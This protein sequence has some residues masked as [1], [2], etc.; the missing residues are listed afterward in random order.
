MRSPAAPARHLSDYLR[1]LYR[2]RW[3]AGA[4]W[5]AVFVTVAVITFRTTPLYEATA[6]IEITA[7]DA[8]GSRS[9]VAEAPG[10]GQ[11]AEF[12]R[13]QYRILES[14]TLAWRAI[15]SLGLNT[16]EAMGTLARSAAQE[17]LFARAVGW[18]AVLAGA[19]ERIPPPAPDETTAQSALIDAFR[20]GLTIAPVPE[21]RL[22][23]VIYR[24]RDPA[25]AAR[26]A[27][28][29]A[30]QFQQQGLK[31]RF[32]AAPQARLWLEQELDDQRHQVEASE[33]ALQAHKETHDLAGVDDSQNQVV[34]KL[35]DVNQKWTAAKADRWEKE[36]DY[37]VLQSLRRDPTGV[38]SLPQ[39]VA[40]P[41]VQTI[42]AEI[43]AIKSEQQ[44]R[45][46]ASVN[47]RLATAEANRRRAVLNI[48]RTIENN[49]QAARTLEATL[50]DALRALEEEAVAL[51]RASIEYEVLRRYA[52]SDRQLYENI[53]QRTKDTGVAAEFPGSG[54]RILDAAEIPRVPVIPRTARNLAA[55]A[56]GG[57][58]FAF[59]LVFGAEYMDSRLKTPDD[60]KRHL[61]LP[62]LG[63]VPIASGKM[64]SSPLLGDDVPPGFGE[65]IRGI[66]TPVMF[67][68]ADS[69]VRSVVVTSTAPGEGKTVV[70]TNLAAALAQAGQRTLI[71]DGDMRR[72]R[73][74]EVFGR[75]QEPGLS[76]VLVNTARLQEAVVPT[77][78]AGLDL[79]P[80][81]NLPPN[82][83]ELLGSARYLELIEELG[84]T[85]AWIVIDAPP[86]LAVTDAA[87][88][89]NRAAGVVFVVGAEMTP[90][91]N[92]AAAIEQLTA[93]RARFIGAVLNKVNLQ[94]HALLYAP[95]YRKEYSRVYESTPHG[96]P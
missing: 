16:P 46:D 60:L 50:D 26:A 62:F 35:A 67:S 59:V 9:L 34:R 91:R 51:G 37:Q 5:A 4:A 64:R 2:R 85:Y 25:L 41:Y 68:S 57:L 75:T 14:R 56:A 6:E 87:V 8:G 12:Y 42:S 24:S 10:S 55:A 58:L 70:S 1:I 65:A 39:V 69:G 22:V 48:T 53:L 89:A 18:M 76:N 78:V 7:A 92:A 23:T 33:R 11:E 73:V 40:N 81:G 36:S 38:A 82:P 90:A 80:A 52:S 71:I 20:A 72:P 95:Y 61:G 86:V 27:N 31:N 79:L 32:L 88:A 93:A 15:S 44:R 77:H 28:A 74:H 17:S 45:Q 43:D 96:R 13:T 94:R 21:T 30:L 63:L 83:A 3:I 19:P 66:R 29:I 49:F 54:V 47:A 84:R